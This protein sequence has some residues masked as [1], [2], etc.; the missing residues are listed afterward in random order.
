MKN[1]FDYFDEIYCINLDERTDRWSDIQIEFDKAGIKDRVK[2]FSAIKENDG[3]IGVIKSN[4]AIVKEAHEKG[5]EN[6]LIFE[7]DMVF[8]KDDPNKY[9]ELAIKEAETLNW[10][11]FFLGANTHGKLIKLKPHLV[12]LKN[13]FACHAYAINKNTYLPFIRKFDGLNQIRKQSDILDVYIAQEIQSVKTCLL[14]NP[15]LCTQKSD[16]SDIEKREVDQ[17]YIEDRFK[18]NIK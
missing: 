16:Y 14:V 3:R 10:S 17:G 12:L 1:P 5:L 4:L 9:L 7:D 8:I 15:M 6:V 13:A 11:M 18:K 2:R